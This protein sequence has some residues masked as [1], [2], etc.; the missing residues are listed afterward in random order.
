[1]YPTSSGGGF[2]WQRL[3][4]GRPI[5][6][7]QPTELGLRLM[8][9]DRLPD[10]AHMIDSNEKPLVDVTFPAKFSPAEKE[11]SDREKL[12]WKNYQLYR[13]TLK[14]DRRDTVYEALATSDYPYFRP[15]QHWMGSPFPVIEPHPFVGEVFTGMRWYE[16][17]TS[18]VTAVL[19]YQYI[20]MKPMIRYSGTNWFTHKYMLFFVFSM[21]EFNFGYRSIWRLQGQVPNEPECYKYGICETPDRLRMKS[22]YWGKFRAYKEEWCRRWD[23]YMWGMRPGERLTFFS[24]CWMPPWPV[25]FN[26]KYDFPIRKNPFVLTDQAV[27]D[28]RLE[29]NTSFTYAEGADSYIERARPEVKY[30]WRGGI[31]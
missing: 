13:L 22:E 15:T 12:A 30:L 9:E 18:A 20:R 27:R 28:M 24:G 7:K 14:M 19:Y 23:Y 25:R 31:G 4:E 10:P 17:V 11:M 8:E 5:H 2:F 26:T 1:M 29:H 21:M 16:H 6:Q 3:F